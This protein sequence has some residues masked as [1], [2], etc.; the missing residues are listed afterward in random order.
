MN[1]KTATGTGRSKYYPKS[2][3]EC[4]SPLASLNLALWFLPTRN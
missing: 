1:N 4:S 3:S 2:V